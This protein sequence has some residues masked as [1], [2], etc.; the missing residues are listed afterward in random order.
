MPIQTISKS[1][2]KQTAICYNINEIAP[3]LA[4]SSFQSLLLYVLKVRVI[5]WWYVQEMFIFSV[6]FN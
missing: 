1:W 6:Q 5:M 4:N 2:R 3:S